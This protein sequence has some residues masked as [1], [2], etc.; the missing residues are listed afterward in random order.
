MKRLLIETVLPGAI[1]VLGVVLLVL[2]MWVGTMRDLHARV[3]GLDRPPDGGTAGAPAVPLVGKLTKGDGQPA[4]LPG[5]WPTFRG[6]RLDGIDHDS[7][8]LARK[9]PQRGP[10]RLWSIEVGEGYASP[11]VLGGRAYLLDYDRQAEADAMRCLSL[12]DGKEIWRFSYPIRV[13]RN[14]GMSRTVPAVT[15]KYLVGLG[16]KCHVTCLD[17][18]SGKSFWLMDLV[19]QHGATVPPWYAGQCPLLDGQ[20]VILATGGKA[21]LIA[22]DCQ[23]GDV[24][25]ESPNPRG[26]R[27][28]HVSI[29]PMELAGRRMYVYC[30]HGGVAGIAADDGSLL[31][32]S[33]DWKISI[34]TVPSPTI[35][36]DGRIFFSGGYNA[37]AVMMRISEQ[38]GQLAAKTLFRLKPNQFGSTQHTPILFDGYLYGV[39]EKDKQLVCM[40]LEG[41][42][43]WK[44]GSRNKFGLGPYMIADGLIFVMDDSG[45]LTMA[46]ATP[47]GYKQL[48][49][50]Q[51]LDG[52]DAWGPMTLAAGRLILRDMTQMVCVD[53]G[54]KP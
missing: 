36:G 25:W 20:R 50:A 39:R 32:D 45:L 17:P 13:K 24:I 27:Q 35:I 53:V 51:V 47:D 30:G 44:S 18:V 1:A 41:A 3:P 23:T 34:A 49:Q 16:P 7:V 43:V 38:N 26:W 46:E 4:D 31:W 40:D 11:A 2:W 29:M 15:D 5:Q 28:T 10:K 37:G 8:R 12:A 21:L 6:S 54:K 52:H 33:T 19:S 22:V 42:E 9:W 14:H 48:D